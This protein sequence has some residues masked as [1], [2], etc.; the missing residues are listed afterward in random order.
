MPQKIISRATNGSQG[1]KGP[2]AGSGVDG[3]RPL[4]RGARSEREFSRISGEPYFCYSEV[5]CDGLVESGWIQE[6]REGMWSESL[7]AMFANLAYWADQIRQRAD[8]VALEYAL[9]AEIRTMGKVIIS[10]PVQRVANLTE[11][12]ET[13]FPEYALNELDQIGSLLTRFS[14]DFW[15]S[16]G[17]DVED[18]L[19]K[20]E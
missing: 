20:V 18:L 2:V 12:I 10:G 11:P 7:T 5:H 14:R 19:Y 17:E 15:H 13:R 4:L 1:F 8:A 16:M 3:W 9:G 6:C